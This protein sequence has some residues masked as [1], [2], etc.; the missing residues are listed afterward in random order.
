MIQMEFSKPSAIGWMI[1]WIMVGILL[2]I[3][4]ASYESL[5]DYLTLGVSLSI[6]WGLL[7]S[8]DYWKDEE[9]KSATNVQE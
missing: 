3:A 1:G 9:D 7:R 4:G 2:R 8:G 6:L 5:F